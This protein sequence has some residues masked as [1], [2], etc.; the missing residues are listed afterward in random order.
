MYNF[1]IFIL[2]CFLSSNFLFSHEGHKH[3]AQ[4]ESI[5]PTQ[6]E[7]ATVKSFGGRP[8]SWMQWLG[9][10]HFIFLHFPLALI[11]MTAISELLF[12]WYSKP[13]FDNAARFML[14]AAAIFALPTALFGLIYSYTGTYE[15]LLATLI[16][17][18]GGLGITTAVFTI[19]AAFLREYSGLNKVYYICLFLLF[20]LVNITGTLGGNLTFGPY[21]MFPPV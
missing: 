3:V 13:I 9:G 17:W 12:A 8:Q 6:N 16:W 2:L 18:H 1:S 20:I 19:I 11:I 4:N 14:I 7:T 15:G 5:H 21:H 10:F